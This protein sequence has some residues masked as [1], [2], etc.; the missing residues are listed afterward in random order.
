MLETL[1]YTIRIGSTPTFL[2]FY[3][4]MAE[5]LA[6]KRKTEYTTTLAWMRCSLSFALLRSAISC[7][8]GTRASAHRTSDMNIEL[9]MAESRLFYI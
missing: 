7:I 4:R 1:D 6:L 3:R 8:R 2:Y 5:L 9:T